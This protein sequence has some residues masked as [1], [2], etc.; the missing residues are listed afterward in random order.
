M[1][2]LSFAKPLNTFTELSINPLCSIIPC[3]SFISL[4]ASFIFSSVKSDNISF[5]FAVSKSF[6]KYA[7]S[8][9]LFAILTFWSD[10]NKLI[11]S[12]KLLLNATFPWS[13]FPLASFI[14]LDKRFVPSSNL[15]DASFKSPNASITLSNESL[16]SSLSKSGISDV[17][18]IIIGPNSKFSTFPSITSFSSRSKSKVSSFKLKLSFKPG[19]DA[20]ATILL[21]PSDIIS[22]L[23]TFISLN[24]ST[25][26]VTT[27]AVIIGVY[28]F[29]FS[30]LIS[31]SLELLFFSSI[32]ILNFPDL[33]IKSSP[34]ISLSS[35]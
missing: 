4:F 26:S 7:S 20:N 14:P 8:I 33:P 35:K 22:P 21:F 16:F 17:A 3:V 10:D 28:I 15:L 18:V 31:T 32:S 5:N 12:F 1:K 23:F 2:L 27:E 30:P 25:G 9:N 29:L 24:L 13:S 11:A 19:T 6:A 34:F